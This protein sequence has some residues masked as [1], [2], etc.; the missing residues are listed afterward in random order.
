MSHITN[1]LT[2]SRRRFHITVEKQAALTL[3]H[4]ADEAKTDIATMIRVSISN[5]IAC[6]VQDKEN[7]N[8]KDTS[9]A[10]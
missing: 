3:Q 10:R 2:R 7:K 5:L 4:M 6:Y 8:A 1:D 9:K